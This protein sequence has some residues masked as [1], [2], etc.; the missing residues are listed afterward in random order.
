MSGPVIRLP[1][2]RPLRS[3]IIL[4]RSFRISLARN[5]WGMGLSCLDAMGLFQLDRV[6]FVDALS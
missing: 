1:A 3:S 6:H 4:L 2:A 5:A